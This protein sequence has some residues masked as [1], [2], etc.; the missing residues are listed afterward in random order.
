MK[1]YWGR[2]T[3]I[4]GV[5]RIFFGGNIF[6][7]GTLFQTNFQKNSKNFQKYSKNIQKNSKNFQKYSKNIQKNFKNFQKIF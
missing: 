3:G 2:I 5:A 4:M 7:G 1:D 6:S